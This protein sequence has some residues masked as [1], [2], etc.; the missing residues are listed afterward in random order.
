[1]YNALYV[2]FFF[3]EQAMRVRLFHFT[4]VLTTV[5]TDTIY[6]DNDNTKL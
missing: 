2:C 1:L 4:I 5:I 3:L 6:D